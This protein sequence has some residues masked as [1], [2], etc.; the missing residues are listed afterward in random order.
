VG[1]VDDGGVADN[2]VVPALVRLCVLLCLQLME[3]ALRKYL[4]KV[5]A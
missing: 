5:K 3:Q 4:P 1:L 2:L